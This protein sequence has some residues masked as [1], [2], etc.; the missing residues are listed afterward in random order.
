MSNESKPDQSQP[1]SR[2][3]GHTPEFWDAR[4]G[5]AEFIYGTAPNAYLASQAKRFAA[6]QRALVPGDGEGRNSVW[7]ASL[8]LAVTA[9]D[10][11]AA[12]VAKGKRLAEERGVSVDFVCAD[13]TDWDWPVATFDVVAAIYL[14]LPP[15]L[16]PRLHRAMA[17]ALKPGGLLVIEAFTPDQLPLQVQYGSGGPNRADML[18]TADLLRA[19]FAGCEPLELSEARID[20]DEGAKHSGPSAVVRGVFR[21][22]AD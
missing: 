7:L 10:L 13:L 8:G 17:A 12:G 6:G 3:G 21:R 1:A 2:F 5:A 11:S 15:E 18:F 9:V 14:H 19:D 16:R 22:N 20:L 4:Y